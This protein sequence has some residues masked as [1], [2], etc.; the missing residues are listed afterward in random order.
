MK[1]ECPVCGAQI[2]LA[3]DAV[4]GELIECPDCGTELEIIT[5][6]PPKVQEAP[7]EEEDWGE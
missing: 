4:Q 6:N 3:A 5:V 7:Q 2:E 1:A